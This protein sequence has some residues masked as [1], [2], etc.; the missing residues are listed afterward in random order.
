[1]G[2]SEC[3]HPRPDTKSRIMMAAVSGRYATL[4]I[5]FVEGRAVVI[6]TYQN[7]L[8]DPPARSEIPTQAPS[9]VAESCGNSRW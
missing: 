9:T 5:Q 2:P 8:L 7:A 4:L 3:A 1:M 6:D